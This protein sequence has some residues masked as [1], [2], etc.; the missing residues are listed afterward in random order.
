VPIVKFELSAALQAWKSS[1]DDHRS[2]CL[3]RTARERGTL[4]SSCNL[5]YGI[6][7]RWPAGEYLLR[8]DEIAFAEAA[9]SHALTQQEKAFLKLWKEQG[10]TAALNGHR[11]GV[12]ARMGPRGPTF[13][14]DKSGESRALNTELWQDV[15]ARVRRSNGELIPVRLLVPHRMDEVGRRFAYVAVKRPE[16]VDAFVE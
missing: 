16:F 14:F 11:M 15:L 1:G 8:A 9:I 7:E 5:V 10:L 4:R 3:A 2:F 12:V 6:D 13:G